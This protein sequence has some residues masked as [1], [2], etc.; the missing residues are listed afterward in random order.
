MFAIPSKT[1]CGGRGRGWRVPF[2]LLF[3]AM[4]LCL[5]TWPDAG[6]TRVHASEGEDESA[7]E[8]PG[9]GGGSE[10]TESEALVS[11]TVEYDGGDFSLVLFEDQS[12]ALASGEWYGSWDVDEDWSEHHIQSGSVTLTLANL[13][14]SA[15][16]ES[17]SAT[18]SDGTTVTEG[19]WTLTEIHAT[20]VSTI[21]FNM[22]WVEDFDLIGTFDS[23][24]VDDVWHDVSVGDGNVVQVSTG[25][26]SRT[27]E[28][29]DGA[30][31]FIE[32][33]SSSSGLTIQ[34]PEGK[35]KVK[36]EETHILP[37]IGAPAYNLPRDKW[38]E[39]IEKKGGCLQDMASPNAV[40]RNCGGNGDHCSFMITEIK[41]GKLRPVVLNGACKE[42]NYYVVI[43][44][45]A[46]YAVARP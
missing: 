20:T 8:E 22:E 39:V 31:V 18:V 28:V 17:G 14:P 15:E 11:V 32:G 38:L 4:S 7:A 44:T 12:V 5:W 6:V 33:E 34:D 19:T 3:A 40:A 13:V 29:P 23:V 43:A 25:F 26:G 42:S 35:T 21:T 9:E 24:L 45:G 10:A 41:D 16:G 37:A 2:A 1:P 46:I 27:I 30:H 36:P